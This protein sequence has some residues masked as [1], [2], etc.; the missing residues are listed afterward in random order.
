MF[1]QNL[2]YEMVDEATGKAKNNFRNDR[3]MEKTDFTIVAGNIINKHS[4]FTGSMQ[5]TAVSQDT[6]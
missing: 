6:V 3:L 2:R 1:S 5:E 4:F